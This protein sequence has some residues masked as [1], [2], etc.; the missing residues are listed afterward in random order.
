LHRH[1]DELAVARAPALDERGED[2]HRQMHAGAAIADIGAVQRRR[3]A[4]YAGDAHRARGRLRDR[5]EAFETAI[6]A[7][8]AE[9]LDRG[10]NGARVEFLHRVVAEPQSLH[11]AGAE[12]LGDDIAF[13]DQAAGDFLPL[14]GLQVD[15]DAALVAVEQQ[16]EKAVE[17]GIVAVPQLA[18]AVAA[19]RVLDL[20]HIGAE[21]GQHLRARRAGLVMGE[22]DD[23]NA[24]ERLAHLSLLEGIIGAFRARALYL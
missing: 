22:I 2:R 21:P 15:D 12:I 1:L 13:L 7:V 9:A 6:R 4:G 3:A 16:E 14:R 17:L 8:G 24:V 11:D 10:V 20:D 19:L 18:G 23:A 5:L